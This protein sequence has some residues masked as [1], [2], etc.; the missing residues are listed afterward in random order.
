MASGNRK[1]RKAR[2][3]ER[4]KKAGKR[5]YKIGGK[6]YPRQRKNGDGKFPTVENLHSQ[7]N[8]KKNRR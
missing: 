3:N 7:K 6:S 2:R 4:K 5:Q 8:G 1:I